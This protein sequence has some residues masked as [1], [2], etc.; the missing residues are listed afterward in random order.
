MEA[1]LVGNKEKEEQLTK[2]SKV[3]VSPTPGREV[4]EQEAAKESHQVQLERLPTYKTE[5]GNL[6][7]SQEWAVLREGLHRLR[8]KQIGGR[9]A[10]KDYHHLTVRSQ[11]CTGA[12][13]REKGMRP[14]WLDEE[15]SPPQIGAEV[16]HGGVHLRRRSET[17]EYG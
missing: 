5:Q 10:N 3:K 11:A 8:I 13:F 14:H 4:E 1:L 17:G 7:G 12:Q 16:E 6:W 2:G 9:C 15:E